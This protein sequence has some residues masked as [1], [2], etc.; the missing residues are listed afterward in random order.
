M[1]RQPVGGMDRRDGWRGEEGMGIGER[2]GWVEGRE[3]WVEGRGG[4]GWREGVERKENRKVGVQLLSINPNGLDIVYSQPYLAD[5][6]Q[7]C[8]VEYLLHGYLCPPISKGPQLLQKGINTLIELG[9]KLFQ[10]ATY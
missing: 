3:G 6:I 7:S 1:R 10:G 5:D 9:E 2:R 4:C 8:L